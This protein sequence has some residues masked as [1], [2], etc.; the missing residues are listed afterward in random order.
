MAFKNFLKF[1]VSKIS[2]MIAAELYF[3]NQNSS[4]IQQEIPSSDSVSKAFNIH[5]PA[6]REIE[7]RGLKGIRD[8]KLVNWTDANLDVPEPL[9]ASSELH[10]NYSTHPLDWPGSLP[11]RSET[12]N[13]H[14]FLLDHFLYWHDQLKQRA[15]WHRKNW[16]FFFVLQSLKERG[17]LS[18][19]MRGIGFGVG[20]ESLP[21]YF[22]SLGI[23]VLASDASI[24][25]A[26]EKGWIENQHAASLDALYRSELVSESLF[27]SNVRFKEIDMNAIPK[28]LGLFDFVWS[29][30]ALEHLGSVEKGLEFMLN[31]TDLLVSGG[32]AV[33]TTEFSLTP[34]RPRNQT[35]DTVVYIDADFAA[36]KKSAYDRGV[37]VEPLLIHKGSHVLDKHVDDEPRQSDGLHVRLMVDG[38]VA[39]CVGFIFQKL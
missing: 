32:V 1:G 21:S 31:S 36:L 7:L 19:G 2:R 18:F 9:L 12:T 10:P 37:Y 14:H 39:T 27:K 4:N 28:D 30:C 23:S 17:K 3:L 26:K 33:H 5:G 34:Q 15:S 13:L 8:F 22:A 25:H 35:G 16:E 38:H 20:E 24:S 29:I 11:L 6:N